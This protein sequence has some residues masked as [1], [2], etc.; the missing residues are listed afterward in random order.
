MDVP[1]DNTSL[2]T[3]TMVMENITTATKG[4]KLLGEQ[5]R[6]AVQTLMGKR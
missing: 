4:D 6:T 3:W 5:N 2:D 1:V